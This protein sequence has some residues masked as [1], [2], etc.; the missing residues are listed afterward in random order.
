MRAIAAQNVRLPA[1]RFPFLTVVWAPDALLDMN[2]SR[3]MAI[4]AVG[5]N[6]Q[7]V[8]L[9]LCLSVSLRGEVDMV[10]FSL[11]RIM[12]LIPRGLSV[13]TCS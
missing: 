11:A 7:P 1:R 5:T 3:D 6:V 12:P 9:T 2:S 10:C 8:G 4:K 13:S